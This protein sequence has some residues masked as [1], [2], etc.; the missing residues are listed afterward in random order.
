MSRLAF[1]RYLA[2]SR[3]RAYEV[4]PVIV[5]LVNRGREVCRD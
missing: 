1:A 3:N 2:G 5:D 4:D